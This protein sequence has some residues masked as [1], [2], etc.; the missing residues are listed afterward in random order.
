[1]FTD[2]GGEYHLEYA[3]TILGK[4]HLFLRIHLK[5]PLLTLHFSLHF[6]CSGPRRVCGLLL[7]T[8]A[9]RA[10]AIRP[11]VV[12]RPGRTE[13]PAQSWRVSGEFQG[14][15]VCEIA[16]ESAP[17]PNAWIA[18]QLPDQFP[19]PIPGQLPNPISSQLSCELAPQLSILKK[20][21]DAQRTILLTK[22]C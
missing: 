2:I 15:L 22:T 19:S 12:R 11:A 4:C 5:T 8:N 17:S 16:A 7:W 14:T 9:S 1:M 10:L 13:Q 3:S 21:N 18:A 6:V 20:K